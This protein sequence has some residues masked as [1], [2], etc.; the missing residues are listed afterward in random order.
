MGLCSLQ[1]I[2]DQIHLT[3]LDLERR[4][5][6]QT[7]YSVEELLVIDAM[8][9]ERKMRSFVQ[10]YDRVVSDDRQEIIPISVA[11]EPRNGASK[12]E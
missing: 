7:R 12:T 9:R 11:S 2:P 1:S 4:F 5:G 8:G 10:R 3:Y 6:L